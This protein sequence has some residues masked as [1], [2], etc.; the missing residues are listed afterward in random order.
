MLDQPRGL[1]NLGNSCFM[2]SALQALFYNKSLT[3]AFLELKKQVRGGIV[4]ECYTNLLKEYLFK[5][6]A[7][8]LAPHKMFRNLRRINSIFYPGEQHDSH[9]FIISL[10]N[11]IEEEIKSKKANGFLQ[12]KIYGKMSQNINCLSCPYV[13]K[14]IDPFYT[15]SLD[16]YSGFSINDFFKKYFESDRLE[17][18]NKYKC[19]GCKRLV[20]A[21]KAYRIKEGN[22][23]L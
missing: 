12:S 2:N 6:G 14:K 18:N 13:S 20:V 3:K 21:D 17:G 11:K 19:S 22:I 1:N 7:G 15:I 5:K 16:I 4:F 8:S 9:E 23:L 10:L